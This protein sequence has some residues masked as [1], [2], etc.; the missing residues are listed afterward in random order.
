MS[1]YARYLGGECLNPPSSK[2]RQST[3][4]WLSRKI[5]YKQKFAFD[6]FTLP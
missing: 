4:A 2:D 5:R 6:A 1:N 3:Q